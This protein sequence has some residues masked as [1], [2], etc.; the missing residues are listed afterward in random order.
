MKTRTLNIS[1]PEGLIKKLDAVAEKEFRNRSE[2]IREAIRRYITIIHE[3]QKVSTIAR[4][5]GREMGIMTEEDVNRVV[6][7]YRHPNRKS[8]S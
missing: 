5:R 7:E 6:D 1:L 4:K 2:L 8:R 3:W